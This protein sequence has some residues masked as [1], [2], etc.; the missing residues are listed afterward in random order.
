MAELDE[1]NPEINQARGAL[2]YGDTIDVFHIGRIK[3]VQRYA[4][5][6]RDQFE[7]TADGPFPPSFREYLAQRGSIRGS[8]V[9]Y[10]LDIPEKF[11]LTV[12][13]NAGRAVFVPRL[14]TELEWQKKVVIEIVS[15]LDEF[16]RIV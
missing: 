7:W 12:A 5:I 13:P 16:V 9:L 8:A 10:I 15:A 6:R 1:P 4:C 14:S 11:Q 2:C 3:V